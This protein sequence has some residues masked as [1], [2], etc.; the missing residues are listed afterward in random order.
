M[1]SPP[2]LKKADRVAVISTAKRTTPEEIEQGIALLKNWG[3]DPVLGN[4]IFSEHY[5]FAGT[6]KERTEDLQQML[7]DNSIKAI[8]FSKGAYGTLR[9]I[10]HIDFN[11]FIEN[12]K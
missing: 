4:H 8:F 11:N 10:D 1:I 6:D 7:N 12:P 2:Y 5:F 9:I 3:L